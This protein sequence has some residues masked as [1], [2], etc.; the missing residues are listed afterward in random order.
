MNRTQLIA[1]ISTTL[2][3]LPLLSLAQEN[4][5]PAPGYCPRISQNLS[6][7]MQ[8]ATTIP[9]GQ[10]T[11]LQKF[12]VDYYDLNPDTYISGYFGR[13]TQQNVIK[14]QAEQGL[15]TSGFVGPL[16]RAAIA[17]VCAGTATP[18]PAN[19]PPTN[20]PPT[21]PPPVAPAPTCSLTAIPTSITL[22]ASSLLTWFA[23]NATAGSITSIG[24]V[25]LSGSQS[26]TPTQTTTY[27]GTFTGAGGATTCQT[28]V[29]VTQ[30]T[31]PPPTCAPD[32]T[33]PQMQTLACPAGQVG[34]ITQTR[35][36]T[37][38]GPT[39]GAWTTTSNTCVTPAATANT[40]TVATVSAWVP[41]ACPSDLATGLSGIPANCRIV[42][43]FVTQDQVF[44]TNYS[45]LPGHPYP[46]PGAYCTRTVPGGSFA[47]QFTHTQAPAGPYQV[48]CGQ[49]F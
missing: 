41:L 5:T 28:T 13:L 43:T 31:P 44:L 12:L 11:E 40:C 36:S 27:I 25:G 20:P 18:P 39:W 9:P 1:I 48:V 42:G 15:P 23:Q 3:A 21:Q 47:C 38:P 19:P 45:N 34:S 33:S 2:L 24:S 14:F 49:Y 26:V 37:C 17:R 29:T 10:V 46:W 35:T 6:R 22:G 4:G 30:P 7:G 32:P 16:T 8:D